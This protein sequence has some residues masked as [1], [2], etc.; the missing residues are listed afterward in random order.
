MCCS[1]FGKESKKCTAISFL[2]AQTSANEH[3]F[4]P[5]VSEKIEIAAY[6]YKKLSPKLS[7]YNLLHILQLL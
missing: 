2:E 1:G 5:V 6:L 4:L 7:L 3:F